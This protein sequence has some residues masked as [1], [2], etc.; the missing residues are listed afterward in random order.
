[1]YPFTP[2][3]PDNGG[4]AS[5]GREWRWWDFALSLPRRTSAKEGRGGAIAEGHV[6]VSASW[7]ALR[8]S[9]PNAIFL[10]V[11]PLDAQGAGVMWRGLVE[12][13]EREA[14]CGRGGLLPSRMR[15]SLLALLAPLTTDR[16]VRRLL[17]LSEVEPSGKRAAM[18]ASLARFAGAEVGEEYLEG[19]EA[20]DGG[21][22]S[23]EAWETIAATL[24]PAPEALVRVTRAAGLLD[25]VRVSQEAALVPL[26]WTI[27]AVWHTRAAERA[28]DPGKVARFLL[29]AARV[30]LKPL[31]KAP[32][33][34]ELDKA[35]DGR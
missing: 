33:T 20:G 34:F 27:A 12:W 26:V 10:F 6:G 14:W 16:A 5:N 24:P 29:G 35:R 1:M 3:S 2:S 11:A 13:V 31:C 9:F 23:W 17:L 19:H 28:C 22:G 18:L 21:G 8:K 32:Q 25:G 7:N 15:A 4:V 30:A